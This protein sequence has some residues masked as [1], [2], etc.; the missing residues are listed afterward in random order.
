MECDLGF[1][2][3]RAHQRRSRCRKTETAKLKATFKA[4]RKSIAQL[5]PEISSVQLRILLEEEE[6]AETQWKT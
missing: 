6:K 2:G 1:R 3:S 5:L 4:K